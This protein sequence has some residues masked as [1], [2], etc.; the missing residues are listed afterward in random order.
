V[1][2]GFLSRWSRRKDAARRGEAAPDDTPDRPAEE[3]RPD[4]EADALTP[5]EIAGLPKPEELT[6]DSD[7]TIFLRRGVPEALRNAALR[8]AWLL[9]PAIRDF[10]GHARDYD[11]DWNGP[12]GVPGGGA[13]DPEEVAA[14]ARRVLGE[15]AE[16]NSAD[17]PPSTPDGR[18]GAGST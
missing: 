14:L 13:L 16:G 15:A 11:F 1:S 4:A 12:G 3:A 10:A 7:I 17:S 9:D 2:E 6:A 5:E 18:S 8:R